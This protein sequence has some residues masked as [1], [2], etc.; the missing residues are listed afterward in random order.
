MG[1]F[2]EMLKYLRKR[3][4]LS[5]SELAKKLGVAKSTISMYELGN[6]EPDFETMELLAD[7]FNVDM[8]FLHGKTDPQNAGYYLDPETAKVAQEIL[9]EDKVL[10]DVYKSSK[11]EWL[12]DFV[13]KLAELEALEKGL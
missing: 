13:K 7:Y 6:R 9:E 8:N 1:E 11:R 2:K 4:G 5:Q 3:A 12:M 10:F